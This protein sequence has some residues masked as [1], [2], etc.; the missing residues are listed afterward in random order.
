MITSNP[1]IIKDSTLEDLE[2]N[3]W[4]EPTFTSNAVISCHN[5]RKIPL[6]N[7][8]IDNLRLLITQKIGLPYI[9]SIAIDF[10]EDNPWCGE[11]YRGDLLL[12]VLQ[13]DKDFWREN[14]A[15]YHRLSEIMCIIENDMELAE[16]QLLP[17]WKLLL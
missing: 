11:L 8:T 13:V 14:Q 16:K 9:V 4:H 6:K 12:A 17:N 5:L 1:L 3:A 7:L 10:L 2:N 15:L